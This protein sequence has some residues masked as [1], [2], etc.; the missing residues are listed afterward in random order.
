MD[1]FVHA[2]DGRRTPSR[3]IAIM[4]VSIVVLS[5]GGVLLGSFI[6]VP[7]TET[8]DPP[9]WRVIG[10]G[11]A[12]L[13]GIV[14]IVVGIVRLVRSGQLGAGMRSPLRSM[15]RP[16]RR[17]IRRR[18]LGVEPT[19]PDEIDRTRDVAELI[20][21]QR[22]LLVLYLGLIVTGVAQALVATTRVL[23][24]IGVGLVVVWSLSLVLILRDARR[25]ERFLAAHLPA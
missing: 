6:D 17:Q 4:V 21:R 24:V 19:P 2:D 9:L 10:G 18:A 20:S 23:A 25:A 3:F 8:P 13:V 14:V 16:D 12:M 7:V 1:D 11:A 5:V 15:S 22:G